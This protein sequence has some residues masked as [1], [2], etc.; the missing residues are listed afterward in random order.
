[1]T[2]GPIVQTTDQAAAPTAFQQWAT[3]VL[4]GIEAPVTQTN[5]DFLAAWARFES[6]PDVLRWNNPLNITQ[7]PGT[8]M[9]SVGVKSFPDPQTG[10]ARTVQTLENGHYPAILTGLRTSQAPSWY[11]QNASS[12]LSTWGSGTSWIGNAGNLAGEVTSGPSSNPLSQTVAFTDPVTG[13]FKSVTDAVGNILH[14]VAL[15]LVGF[16]LIGIGLYILFRPSVPSAT[17]VSSVAKL[18]AA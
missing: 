7:G 4:Q 16:L 6:G 2:V 12:D 8:D 18:A 11:A 17:D 10:A 14:R 3:A 5:I 13:A 15:F 1:M 9:N